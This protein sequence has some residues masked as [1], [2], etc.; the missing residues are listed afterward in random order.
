VMSNYRRAYVAGGNYFFTLV[1][2]RRQ[3]VFDLE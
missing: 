3:R 1:T 2:W